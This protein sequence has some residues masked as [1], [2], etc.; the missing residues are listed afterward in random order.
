VRLVELRAQLRDCSAQEFEFGALLVAQFDAPIPRL[1]GLSH[2]PVFAVRRPAP[3]RRAPCLL[4]GPPIRRNSAKNSKP[5]RSGGRAPMAFTFH[6]CRG[7]APGDSPARARGVPNR[8]RRSLLSAHCRGQPSRAVPASFLAAA[9]RRG[10]AA[11][12]RNRLAE[13]HHRAPSAAPRVQSARCA[14]RPL[15]SAARRRPSQGARR[16]SQRTCDAGEVREQRSG[17][18]VCRWR[19][20]P[21]TCVLGKGYDVGPI[22]EAC[23]D[24]GCRPIIPL[25]ETLAVRRGDHKP[26][27][28]ERA[29]SRRSGSATCAH[30]ASRR[31]PMVQG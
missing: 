31:E 16:A 24:R 30:R 27:G 3:A 25:R 7:A 5:E 1:I 29:C 28:C 11:R 21:K 8:R 10:L 19:R 15:A 9:L 22:R 18:P 6:T 23:E 13:H 12:Q 4:F 26:P 17:F 2:R 20:L 14:S